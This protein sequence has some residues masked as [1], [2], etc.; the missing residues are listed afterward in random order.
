M[1]G[2]PDQDEFCALVAFT[3]LYLS[4]VTLR[5]SMGQV[6]ANPLASVL[7]RASLPRK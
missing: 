1:H 6:E 5:N 7:A 3:Y 4:S 2:E